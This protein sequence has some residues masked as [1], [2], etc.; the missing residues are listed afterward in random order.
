MNKKTVSVIIPIY[1]G[2]RYIPYWLDILSKN[3]EKLE[4]NEAEVLFINDYPAE[5]L[6][7]ITSSLDFCAKVYNTNIN[8]GIHGARVYGLEHGIF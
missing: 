1:K 3:V 4:G 6:Q 5:E 7:Q 2:E 8:R